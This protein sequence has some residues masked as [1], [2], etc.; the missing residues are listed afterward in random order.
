MDADSIVNSYFSQKS[1]QQVK[2]SNNPA[3]NIV[4]GFFAKQNGKP[5]PL[6]DSYVAKAEADKGD[7]SYNNYC[8]AFVEKA[9]G[10]PNMGA[11]ATQAWDNYS[12]QGKAIAGDITNAPRGAILYF[13]PDNS[14][15]GDGHAGFSDGKGNLVSATSQGVKS[16][17]ISEWQ[18]QT[19]QTPLGYVIPNK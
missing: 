1:S 2:K 18:K 17:P 9:A 10:L 14:N 6:D 8:E 12:K 11:S 13:A 5:H 7:Q 15:Y 16:I 19:G 3:D 4:E